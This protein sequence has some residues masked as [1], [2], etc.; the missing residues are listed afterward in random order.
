MDRVG[1][2]HRQEDSE[3]AWWLQLATTV[4]P[5]ILVCGCGAPRSP[6]GTSHIPSNPVGPFGVASCYVARTALNPPRIPFEV[7]GPSRLHS[8]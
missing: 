7:L 6:R 3:G 2:M 1:H 5:R 4:G 8:L